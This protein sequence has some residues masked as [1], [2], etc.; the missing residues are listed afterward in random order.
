M[1]VVFGS[2]LLV[3]GFAH[4]AGFVVPWRILRLEEM[5]YKTTILGGAVDLGDV[6]IRLMGG[7]WLA[8]SIAFVVVAIGAFTGAFWWFPIAFIVT[9]VSLFMT[10]AGWPD[11]W[12]GAVVNV[13]LLV[14]LGVAAYLGWRTT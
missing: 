11:S 2:I 9:T 12:I 6:G 4:L 13:V 5:P 14:A 8:T 10:F 7:L 1:H 3:H